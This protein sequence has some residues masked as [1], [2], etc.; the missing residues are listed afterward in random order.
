MDGCLNKTLH[1][2]GMQIYMLLM[3]LNMGGYHGKVCIAPSRYACTLVCRELVCMHACNHGCM[4]N[5][6]MYVCMHA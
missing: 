6:C 2:Q 1:V 5:P 3:L 4:Y